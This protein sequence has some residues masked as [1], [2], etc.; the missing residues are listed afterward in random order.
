MCVLRWLTGAKMF[1]LYV[2]PPRCNAFEISH[3]V[4]MLAVTDIRCLCIQ[5]LLL[6]RQEVEGEYQPCLVVS[7]A[8]RGNRAQ[9]SEAMFLACAHRPR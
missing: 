4:F 7:T 5:D 1:R 9:Q 8:Q 3:H 2:V 6:G